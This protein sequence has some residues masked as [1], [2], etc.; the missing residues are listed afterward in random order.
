MVPPS[1]LTF[2]LYYS[3]RLQRLKRV[4][5]VMLSVVPVI[6]L[7]LVATNHYHQLMFT[8]FEIIDIKNYRLLYPYFGPLFWVH[9]A[10]S[11]SILAVGFVL[12]AKHLIDSPTHFTAN[13]PILR[14]EAWPHG[15]LT[16][17]SF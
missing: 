4:H 2:G 12:F 15:Y 10:Y 9:T 16:S 8:R 5:L 13:S 3:N 6:T 1:W 11:Y 7:L 17:C 14:L